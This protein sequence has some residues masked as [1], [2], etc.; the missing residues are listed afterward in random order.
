MTLHHLPV[1][2]PILP[3]RACAKQQGSWSLYVQT[4]IHTASNTLARRKK[5]AILG[6]QFDSK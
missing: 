3:A 6:S 5:V 4:D 2:I 1:I